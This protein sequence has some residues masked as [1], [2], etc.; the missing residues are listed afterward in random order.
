MQEGPDEG[1]EKTLNKQKC[2]A[3]KPHHSPISTER[4]IKVD[5]NVM[6][7]EF[8]QSIMWSVE[9]TEISTACEKPHKTFIESQRIYW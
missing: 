9:N 6:P 8:W 2:Q 5:L 1:G 4:H 3:C 7:A